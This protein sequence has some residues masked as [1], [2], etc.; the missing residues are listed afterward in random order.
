V[1]AGELKS[2][3]TVLFFL[4]LLMQMS[5]GIVENIGSLGIDETNIWL[6]SDFVSTWI[7][8]TEKFFYNPAT[9]K[10]ISNPFILWTPQHQRIAQVKNVI[11]FFF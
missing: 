1:F 11:I 10:I 5:W 8:Y 7:K 6:F 9:G 2:I 3:I 4:M